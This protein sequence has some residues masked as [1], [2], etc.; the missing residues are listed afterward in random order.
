MT[1]VPRTLL[2][3]T[4][5]Q[6]RPRLGRVRDNRFLR[7]G[8]RLLEQQHQIWSRRSRLVIL[9]GRGWDHCGHA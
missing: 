1:L 5:A 9:P 3:R 4:P 7:P 2:G 6:A 8:T